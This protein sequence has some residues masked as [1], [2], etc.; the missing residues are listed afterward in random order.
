MRA[1]LRIWMRCQGSCRQRSL[2]PPQSAPR[3]L[4]CVPR[5][6]SSQHQLL[7]SCEGILAFDY[8]LVRSPADILLPAGCCQL[9][10]PCPTKEAPNRAGT[11]AVQTARKSPTKSRICRFT[12]EGHQP[13]EAGGRSRSGRL[14][15]R[16]EGGAGAACTG[17]EGAHA[18]VFTPPVADEHDQNEYFFIQ[19]NRAAW[20]CP[21]PMLWFSSFCRWRLPPRRVV[22][23]RAPP[24][25]A[26]LR[27]LRSSVWPTR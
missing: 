19:L 14:G 24:P 21:A 17:G 23:H 11:E 15:G 1:V 3:L 12:G 26:P 20:W 5:C 8:S 9:A 25:P 6:V 4:S 22:T 18:S 16:L 10:L 7:P 13:G 2:P 27:R